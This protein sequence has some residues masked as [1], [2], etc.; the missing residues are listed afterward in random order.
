MNTDEQ[1]NKSANDSFPQLL[2]VFE[3][4]CKEIHSL[5]SQKSKKLKDPITL[6]PSCGFIQQ[7]TA[8]H[9]RVCGDAVAGFFEKIFSEFAYVEEITFECVFISNIILKE[10]LL[11]L[12]KLKKLTVL[13]LSRNNLISYLDLISFENLAS[14]SRM[15]IS[16]NQ[17]CACGLLRYFVFYRFS[18]ITNFN[19]LAKKERDVQTTKDIYLKFDKLLKKPTKV[20]LRKG[21]DQNGDRSK[22][23]K[24]IT[25]IFTDFL[26]RNFSDLQ[27]LEEA[28]DKSVKC[29]MDNNLKEAIHE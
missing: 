24:S 14:V 18:K 11:K 27:N 1:E 8:H 23:L 29:S 13:N 16:N 5:K 15:S 25:L 2:E 12:Q 26:L 9:V 19:N 10:N 21:S 3:T 22:C 17:I 4:R 20:A 28:V 6:N 7:I